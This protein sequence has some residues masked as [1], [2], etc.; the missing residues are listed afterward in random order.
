[1]RLPA[2]LAWVGQDDSL[3]GELRGRFKGESR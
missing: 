3:K 2:E 1:M